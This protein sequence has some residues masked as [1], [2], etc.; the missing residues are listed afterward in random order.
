M[1]RVGP[2]GRR[3]R[4]YAWES[5]VDRATQTLLRDRCDAATKFDW[6]TE[7]LRLHRVESMVLGWCWE[8]EEHVLGARPEAGPTQSS[9]SSRLRARTCIPRHT[10][11]AT[12]LLPTSLPFEPPRGGLD[13][14]K[15]TLRLV[16]LRRGKEGRRREAWP[17]CRG[18][19]VRGRRTARGVPL[20]PQKAWI[21]HGAAGAE[22]SRRRG[23]VEPTRPARRGSVFPA[24]LGGTNCSE[25]SRNGLQA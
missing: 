20:S 15:E 3:G 1:S 9:Q 21:Y 13:N 14:T 17:G 22:S 8:A 18:Q 19:A 25:G 2:R 10:K 4:C 12:L 7:A 5:F 11:A 24:G 16:S 23:D 6:N